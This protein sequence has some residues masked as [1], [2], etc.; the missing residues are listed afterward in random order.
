[1][2]QQQAPGA[3]GG[4]LP[5]SGPPRAD[6]GIIQQA[7]SA[8]EVLDRAARAEQGCA[9]VVVDVVQGVPA[10]AVVGPVLCRTVGKAQPAVIGEPVQ[11]VDDG[12]LVFGDGRL[13]AETVDHVGRRGESADEVRE[14]DLD[15]GSLEDCQHQAQVG[16][17]APVEGPAA[18]GGED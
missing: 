17:S 1:M 16:Q 11:D 12:A 2:F 5:L 13:E 15:P 10:L 14:A 3:A 6:V 18:S 4:G 8:R 9:D 7:D